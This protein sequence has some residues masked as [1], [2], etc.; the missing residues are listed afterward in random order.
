MEDA[1][2]TY[3]WNFFYYINYILY[4]IDCSK[5]WYF[6]DQIDENL[7]IR[8]SLFLLIFYYFRYGWLA[9]KV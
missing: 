6:K 7:D 5:N 2:K 8:L 9:Q 1:Q 3:F 4:K